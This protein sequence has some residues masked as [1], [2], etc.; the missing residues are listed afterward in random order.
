VG[1]GAAVLTAYLDLSPELGAFVAGFLLAGTPVRFQL[2]GQIGPM[3]NL[4]MAVFF[5]AVGLT[6]DI[7]EAAAMWWV[8][9][10]AL[11]ATLAVKTL[12]IGGSA[13]LFGASPASSLRA[14]LNL[15]QA[16]EFSLVVLG[17]A[18]LSGVLGDDA[19]RIE[20]VVIGV[21]FLSLL[22]TPG[23]MAGSG[24]LVGKITHWPL[25]PLRTHAAFQETKAAASGRPL[26]VVAGFGPVGR[27]V[28]DRLT[29]QHVDIAVIEMN[30]K[31]VERQTALGRRIIYGD[32]TNPEVLTSAGVEGA[33]AV[34][35]TIPDDE[36]MLRAC[37]AIRA[38]NSE[39][40][41]AARTEYLSRAFLAREFGANH[42]IVEEMATAEA[43]ATQV[44]E[45]CSF[46]EDEPSVGD[47]SGEPAA[48]QPDPDTETDAEP[49]AEQNAEP[50]TELGT[51]P[52]S[53]PRG[54]ADGGS[55]PPPA[56]RS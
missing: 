21:V 47:G 9:L 27:A 2:S 6:L 18:A 55:S 32:V 39:A 30:R 38:M 26:V 51:G 52:V 8:L 43:M 48:K 16:G 41:I 35:L 24:S 45:S 44:I 5:T 23:V 34:V 15:S 36:V 17:A 14:G 13:W 25:N 11:A 40:Y 4:F 7:G 28:A 37:K 10:I 56:A 53:A 3:R 49:N 20:T 54:G 46:A 50:D 1:L 31:T 12:A 29:Q 22:I 33:S 19:A 42:V